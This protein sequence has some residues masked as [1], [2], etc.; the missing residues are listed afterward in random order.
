MKIYDY[1]DEI[2][3]T[4]NA[5]ES[6]G[7]PTPSWRIEEYLKDIYDAIQSGIY[8]SDEQ[9][10][11]AIDAWLDD[12]PE[13]TT[14]VEDGSIT[15]A[16]LASSFVTPGTASAYSSSATYAV[17]DYCFHNGSLYR[18]ITAITT[19]EAWTAEH[20]TAAVLGEDVGDLKSAIDTKFGFSSITNKSMFNRANVYESSAMAR[21][22]RWFINHAFPKG[23]V[24]QE[25]AFAVSQDST[26]SK[27]VSVEIWENDNGTLNK[28][29]SE[30]FNV[31]PTIASAGT[32]VTYTSEPNY[33]VQL[34]AYVCLLNTGNGNAVP[35]A[36]DPDNLDNV[37]VSTDVTPETSTL[38][39][40]SLS[41]FSIKLIP[42]ITI[43]YE[44]ISGVNVVTIGNGM[45]YE[46]IQDAL[47]A[48]TDDTSINPYTL[49][50]FPK[51]EPYKPFSMVRSSF[52]DSYPWSGIQ[53][54]YI[55]IIGI[56]KEHCIIRSDSGNYKLPCGEP[57]TNGI[58]KNL[59]FIMTNEDQDFSATQG[60]YC[61]HIDCKPLNDVGYTMLIEDCDFEDS[62]GPCLGIGVHA[63]CDLQVRRCR[64]NTTLAADYN[65]HEGYTNLVNYGAVFCHT[66]TSATAPNQ[67]FT[68]E[69][70]VGVCAEGDKALRINV[71]TQY[72]P[73]TSSF[74]YTLLRNIFWN[75]SL[76]AP[77]YQI[78]SSLTANP[79]NFGN[80]NA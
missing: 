1:L 20:W 18:C 59:K 23:A 33:T 39:L 74:V 21:T 37:L 26:S 27:S 32:V 7:V 12:H 70:C 11:E 72:D 69:D 51:G 77:G 40:S 4:L 43:D 15:N 35:Y 54:R 36:T 25:V 14:T 28:V 30:S 71:T 62:S 34:E 80:N 5:E 50:V 64:F 53:P 68:L 76:A 56:D 57:L 60:G 19:A 67:R 58:I 55:S 38:A 24:I 52:S 42:S 17:G 61:L 9:V 46:E 41:T 2:L 13:A 16:K 31:T 75:T 79:M 10:A 48:I 22:R 3:R 8:P 49:L 63:N 73:S 66:S 45:D 6:S 65:P 78:S 29:A 47:V 44:S